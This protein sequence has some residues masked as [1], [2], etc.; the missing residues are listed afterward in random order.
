MTDRKETTKK[1]EKKYI[2]CS[3]T[4]ITTNGQ[5]IDIK[6]ELLDGEDDGIL[7]EIREAIKENKIYC[8]DYEI[9]INFQGIRMDELDC[10]KVIGI[11]WY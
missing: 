8:S 9:E 2:P 1:E 7:N 4:L 10:S 6:Y 3:L 5:G 11:Q